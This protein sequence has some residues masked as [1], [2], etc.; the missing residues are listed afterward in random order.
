MWDKEFGQDGGNEDIKK[1]EEIIIDYTMLEYDWAPEGDWTAQCRC[2][3]KNCRKIV[4]GYKYLPSKLKKKY[5]D[6]FLNIC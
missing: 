6:S 1:D 5:R 2:W 4:R 3:S